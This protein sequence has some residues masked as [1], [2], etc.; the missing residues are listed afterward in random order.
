MHV[1]FARFPIFLHHSF[2]VGV[3]SRLS[4]LMEIQDCIFARCAHTDMAFFGLAL[5]C[6]VSYLCNQLTKHGLLSFKMAKGVVVVARSQ[7][8]E[9][10]LMQENPSY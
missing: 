6:L 10:A 3:V 9:R 5:H 1:V 4:H 7:N 8:R 2:H